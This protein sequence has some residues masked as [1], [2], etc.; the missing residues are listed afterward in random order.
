MLAILESDE[1]RQSSLRRSVSTT[2]YSLFHFLT[3]EAARCFIPSTPPVLRPSFQRSFEHKKMKEACEGVWRMRTAVL[4]G[5][6]FV[7]P[8]QSELLEMARVFVALQAARQ[9]A[10]YDLLHTLS[11]IETLGHL[12]SVRAAISGWKTISGS[13][14]AHVF[15]ASLAGIAG[16]R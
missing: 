14:N 5:T 9:S 16:R 3:E 7:E 6:L 15:L 1:P 12:M 4:T 11:R 13:A 2:Y 8:L 10:D